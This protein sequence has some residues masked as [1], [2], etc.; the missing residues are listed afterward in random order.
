MLNA[1]LNLLCKNCNFWLWFSHKLKDECSY[2]NNTSMKLVPDSLDALTWI[3][4][5]AHLCQIINLF[6]CRAVLDELGTILCKASKRMLHAE[7]FLN[8]SLTKW[9]KYIKV[10]ASFVPRRVCILLQWRG[11]RAVLSV[12]DA[13]LVRC[14]INAVMENVPPVALD[15]PSPRAGYARLIMH[16]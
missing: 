4:Y 11:W 2:V 15:V 12:M 14:R 10:V 7:Y 8:L 3:F 5:V 6:Q 9:Q 1:V 13:V 16:L